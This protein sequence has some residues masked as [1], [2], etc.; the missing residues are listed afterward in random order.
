MKSAGSAHVT[1]SS[2]PSTLIGLCTLTHAS[3]PKDSTKG[4]QPVVAFHGN[5]ELNNIFI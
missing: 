1:K 2:S 4:I 3:G 5:G